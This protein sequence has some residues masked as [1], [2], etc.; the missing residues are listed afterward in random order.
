M[1]PRRQTYLEFMLNCIVTF[2]FLGLVVVLFAVTYDLSCYWREMQP[3]E[4]DH[5]Q[6]EMLSSIHLV[7]QLSQLY[8][9][10]YLVAYVIKRFKVRWR[11]LN[12]NNGLYYVVA[13][14][15]C[16]VHSAFNI[17]R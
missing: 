3:I 16:A 1:T 12:L 13:L 14:C 6:V 2:G 9:V 10:Y 5:V 15:Q 7:A 4:I 8:N 17:E 11:N